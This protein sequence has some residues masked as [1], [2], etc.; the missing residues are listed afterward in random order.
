MAQK[1][2]HIRMPGKGRRSPN[3]VYVE[4]R[5]GFLGLRRCPGCRA[6]GGDGF[7]KVGAKRKGRRGGRRKPKGALKRGCWRLGIGAAL[8]GVGNA[9]FGSI[10]AIVVSVFVVVW[11]LLTIVAWLAG[12]NSG[13]RRRRRR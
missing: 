2:G 5:A 10:G 13:G 4:C 12:P 6:C 3:G 1:I 8:I 11:L 9:R 7:R